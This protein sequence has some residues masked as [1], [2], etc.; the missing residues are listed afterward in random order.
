MEIIIYPLF[1]LLIANA[2]V[3]IVLQRMFKEAISNVESLINQTKELQ[4]KI[5]KLEEEVER[6][7]YK[8]K[9]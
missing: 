8:F 1:V 9:E 2:F 3:T 6:I 7:N 4:Q 5:D